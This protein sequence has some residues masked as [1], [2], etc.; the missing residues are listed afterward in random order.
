MSR[1]R[2][3]HEELDSDGVGKCSGYAKWPTVPNYEYTY[4]ERILDAVREALRMYD[5]QEEAKP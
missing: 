2:K 1:L 3:H 5:A 4:L